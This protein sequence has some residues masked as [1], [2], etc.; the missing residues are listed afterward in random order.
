MKAYLSY[1]IGGW[2]QKPDEFIVNLH[3]ISSFLAKKHFKE[4]HFLTDNKSK[5]YFKDIPFDSVECIFDDLDIGYNNVWSVSKLLAYKHICE[6]GD[7][8]IHIDYDVFLWKGLQ[9][10]L[11]NAEVFAQC[12]EHNSYYWYGIEQFLKHC[13]NSGLIK[14]TTPK[15]LHGIN[16]G[17]FGG[18]NLDFIKRYTQSSL[19]IIFDKKNKNFFL[20]ENVF[21]EHWNRAVI[22]EQ[23]SLACAASYYKVKPELYFKN[24]WPSNQEANKKKYTHLM[25][26]KH[27]NGIKEKINLISLKIDNIKQPLLPLQTI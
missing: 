11:K 14:E 19:D 2:R 16:V 17:I 25:G 15:P 10:R 1:W 24:G 13:P 7:P 9:K 27:N 8:F 20:G 4:V 21:S 3:K 23:Y 26:A 5:E 18:N 12:E 6:K 22:V